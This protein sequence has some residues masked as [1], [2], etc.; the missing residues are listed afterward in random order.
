MTKMFLNRYI[1]ETTSPM[2]INSGRRETGFDTQLARDANDLPYIPATS[3]TGV[4]RHLTQSLLGEKQVKQWFGDLENSDELSKA[5]KLHIHHGLLIDAQ[6]KVVLGLLPPHRIKEDGILQRLQDVRPHYRDHVRIN[7]RGV[8]KDK[9]KFDKIVLPTGVRFCVD[10]RWQ[11]DESHE[12]SWLAL[13]KL[14]CHPQFAL[15]S[16]TRNGLG[17]FKIVA[18]HSEKIDLTANPAAGAQLVEFIERTKL[19]TS[20]NLSAEAG[21][22]FATLELSA[23]DVWRCGKGSRPVG[24]VDGHTDSFVYSEPRIEWKAQKGAWSE[25]DEVVLCGSSIKGILAH[26]VAYH[27]RRITG[28]FAD[29]MLEDATHE[30]WQERPNE[31]RDLLGDDN[32]MEGS[33][34]AGSLIVDDVVIEHVQ[35]VVR[36]HTSI[37]RFTGG[38]RFGALYSEEVLWQPTFKVKLH[39]AP[40]THIQQELKEALSATLEDLKLGLLPLGA[41]SGRG[42]SLVEHKAGQV[43]DI[44]WNQ[45]GLQEKSV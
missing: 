38:V 16:S 24:K 4:W 41:G 37:D 11:G 8:A 9:A 7:D 43:W 25:K 36:T 33:E 45:I 6:G 39:I 44:Q 13:E 30:K 32:Q 27:Y 29:V 35:P 2:A 26:R 14:L 15:G 1:I 12:E 5:P 28:Q 40:N 22:V 31:L 18:S 42:N 21:E 23:L 20:T 19:P 10:V 3:F 17:R 34:L